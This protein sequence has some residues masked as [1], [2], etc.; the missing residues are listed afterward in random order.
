MAPSVAKLLLNNWI[1][2]YGIPTSLLSDNGPRLSSKLFSELCSFLF[3]DLKTTTAHHPQVNGQ[4]E[5]YSKI[6]FTRLRHY[7]NEHQSNWD[8]LFQPLTYAYN[9][10]VYSSTGTTPF[11]LVLSRHS[12]STCIPRSDLVPTDSTKASSALIL[13]QQILY[14]IEVM[15]SKMDKTS[16]TALEYFKKYFDRR[17]RHTKTFWS[18]YSIYLDKPD[19]R[20][21]SN[22]LK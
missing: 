14:L 8:A 3:T 11:S 13:K 10:H 2:P 16:A 4:T 9:N 5:R 18:G 22:R 20:L 15:R 12:T 19:P 17:I 7:V 21:S 6:I 1:I